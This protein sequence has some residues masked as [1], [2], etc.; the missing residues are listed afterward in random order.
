MPGRTAIGIPQ[1]GEDLSEGHDLG[2]RHSAGSELAIEVPDRQAIEKR[3][4]FGVEG[5]SL[6]PERVEVGDQVA[7]YSESIDQPEH[8]RL[9]LRPMRTP[10]GRV[11]VDGPARRRIRNAESSE[12]LVVEVSFAEQQLMD[13]WRAVR[14]TVH[15]G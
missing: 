3:I 6:L 13:P 7:A 11:V 5:R 2:P 4:E 1:P 14:P 8:V 15:P 12:H 9:L 10:R